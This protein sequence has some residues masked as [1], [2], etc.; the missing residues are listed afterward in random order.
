MREKG[1]KNIIISFRKYTE[2]QSFLISTMKH[3][4]DLWDRSNNA[5]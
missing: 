5:S 3:K 4:G 2:N 1:E